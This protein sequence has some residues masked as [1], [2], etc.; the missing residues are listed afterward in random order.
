MDIVKEYLSSGQLQQAID[1]AQQRLR[2]EPADLDLRAC[3]VE[4]LCL[5]GQLERADDVLTSLARQ[6]PDWLPGSANL[7]QLLRAQQARLALRKG[8]LADDV[9]VSAG[10]SLEALLALNLHL[11]SGKLA[12]ASQAAELLEA[13]RTPCEFQVN[14]QAGD[15]RDCDDSL[16]GYLEGLGTDG[17]YYLWQWAEIDAVQFHAP[18]SPVEL[19]WRRAVLDLA[20]GRQGEAFIPLTYPDSVTDAQKLGRETDWNEVAPGVVTGVGQKLFLFGESAV[21]FESLKRIERVHAEE[22]SN[23]V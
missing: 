15:I 9:V 8:Q 16:N 4:L 2:E 14:G 11:S 5:A 21:A 17:C 6:N 20:D 12:E 18:A 22:T 23:A 19:I 1:Q 10:A 7:R 13:L 3:L